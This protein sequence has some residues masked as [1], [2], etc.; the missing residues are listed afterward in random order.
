MDLAGKKKKT[1][2]SIIKTKTFEYIKTSRLS[3]WMVAG[4]F[5]LLGAWYSSKTIL[6]LPSL[7][8]LFS[9]GAIL[10]SA[11]WINFVFD[12]ELDAHAGEDISFFNHIPPR[13]MLIV[14]SIFFIFGLFLLFYINI[15]AVF[16]GVLFVL[17]SIIYSGPPFRLKIHPPFDSFANALLFGIFPTLIGFTLSENYFFTQQNLVLLLLSGLIVGCYYLLVDIF[18][19]ESDREYGIKTSCTILGLHRA[20]NVALI[21]FIISIFLSFFYL[22]LF[23]PVTISLL[24]CLPFFAFIKIKND[25][26][27]VA[28]ILSCISFFW[29]EVSLVYLFVLSK[30]IIPLIISI[31]V[32]CSAAYFLYVYIFIIKK[33]KTDKL[34]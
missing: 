26:Q 30:S 32:I 3:S 2:L 6:F 12:K 29:T 5:F 7:V 24:I 8:A 4:V 33:S 16:V 31:M 27:T 28:K 13:E 19:L 1:Y 20:I 23:S 14:S 10:S 22:K 17:I 25:V 21:L 15:F 11:S 34:H 18:D 9:L